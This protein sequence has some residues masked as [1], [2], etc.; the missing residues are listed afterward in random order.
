MELG[1]TPCPRLH[2]RLRTMILTHNDPHTAPLLAG[3]VELQDHLDIAQ[4]VFDYLAHLSEKC[5]F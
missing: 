5:L 4:D 1:V 2:P 3:N